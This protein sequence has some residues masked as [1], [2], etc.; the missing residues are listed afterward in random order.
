MYSPMRRNIR[1]QQCT[2]AFDFWFYFIYL[3]FSCSSSSGVGR[4]TTK[5]EGSKEE[6]RQEGADVQN[7]GLNL[8]I[9]QRMG[10]GGEGGR[11]SRHS[12]SQQAIGN[13]KIPTRILLFLFLCTFSWLDCALLLLLCL[14]W[15]VRFRKHNPK[16][17]LKIAQKESSR[18]YICISW[19]RYDLATLEMSSEIFSFNNQ[20][21]WGPRSKHTKGY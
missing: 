6:D 4:G 21:T 14:G 9:T 8:T 10:G 7:S 15:F 20:S 3:S 2:S 11:W 19:I 17:L 18:I 1:K 16:I 12:L 13:R 5:K